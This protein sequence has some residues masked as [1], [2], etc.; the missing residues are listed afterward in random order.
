MDPTT[1]LSQARSALEV[2][3]RRTAQLIRSLPDLDRRIPGSE[4]TVREAAVHLVNHAGLHTEI[5]EGLASPIASVTKEA[6]AAENSARIA[7]IPEAGGEKVASLLTDAVAG[8]LEATVN[9]S[10]HQPVQFHAGLSLDLAALA[11]ISLG[12]QIL[13]GYDIATALGAPWPIE[14][15]HADLAIHGYGPYYGCMVD[16]EMAHGVT[17]GFGIYLRGGSSFT[18]RFDDG[19]YRLEPPHS[20]PVDCTIAADPVAFLLMWSGRMSPWEAIALNLYV[21]DGQDSSLG[22]R[23]MELF[24]YP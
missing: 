6:L 7:D 4:W 12:E 22:L 13:H 2:T 18:V 19:G 24:A 15:A 8:L 3:A 9:R 10:G 1:V 11:C 21:A 20:G 14:P 16:P 23:F 5:A 17:A